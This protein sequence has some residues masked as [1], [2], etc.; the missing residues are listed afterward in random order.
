[1]RKLFPLPLVLA[2]V[3]GLAACGGGAND[4]PP[5]YS[6][7]LV[8]KL[9]EAGAFSEELEELD[10]DT[11]FL[12]YRLADSGLERA[13]MKECTVLRSAGA[14]CEEGA[15]LVFASADQANTA[16]DALSSYIDGQITANEDYRPGELPKLEDALISRRG[17]T[18]LLVV[19]GD[20]DAA[21][22][23]VE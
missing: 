13:D 5:L 16:V 18:V 19:A 6:A 20:I 10:A 4:A 7:G 21:K 17:E 22:Q 1:M 23:A 3:L 14:T 2:L 8:T 9:V 12:L 15:V 11:A